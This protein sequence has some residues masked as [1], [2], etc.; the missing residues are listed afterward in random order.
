MAPISHSLSLLLISAYLLHLNKQRLT[1]FKSNVQFTKK[2]K[3]LKRTVVAPHLAG[4][5][6]PIVLSCQIWLSA[7]C[8]AFKLRQKE[9][10]NDS[11]YCTSL[12]GARSHSSFF[13]APDKKHLTTAKHI[14]W[15]LQNEGFSRL[16]PGLRASW[17]W[18]KQW[19]CGLA[20]L[21]LRALSSTWNWDIDA[22][23]TTRATSVT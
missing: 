12:L 5:D 3:N 8:Q 17:A 1:N 13:F 10:L 18:V 22:L 21:P 15:L 19:S 14:H 11:C 4:L 2:G 20:N 7:F 9:G 6:E 16:R 23:K